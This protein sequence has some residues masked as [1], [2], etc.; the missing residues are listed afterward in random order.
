MVTPLSSPI[1]PIN[2]TQ[3]FEDF[4]RLFEETPGEYKYQEQIKN[5]DAKGRKTLIILYEDLLS[6][7]SQ[8]A[9]MLKNDPEILI[10]D[11]IKAFKNILKFHSGGTINYDEY[12]V[13]ITTKDEKSPL[14]ISIRGLRSKNIDKL[15]CVK[16]ITIRSSV[17]RPKLIKAIFECNICGA[18]FEVLQLTSSIRWPNFCHN[19]RCKAKAKS[20]FRLISKKS[21]FIDWQSITVQE[22]PEDLPPGRIPRAIQAILTHDLVDYVKPGDRIKIVGIFKSVIATS[23][24]SNNSTLFKTF[25]DVNYIDPEDKSEEQIDI[26]KEEKKEIEKLAKEPFIQRKITRSIAPTIYGRNDLKMACALTLFAGTRKKKI[27]GNY[28][29]GDIHVLFVGDPGTGKSIHGSEKIYIGTEINN[30]KIWDLTK[31]SDFIDELMNQNPSKIILKGDSEVLKLENSPKQYTYSINF[32]NFKTQI[33]QI[34]EISRHMTNILIKINTKNGRKIIATPNHSF[35]T[36]INGKLELI[37]ANQLCEIKNSN[38]LSKNKKRY[39]LPVA[40]NLRCEVN[41]HKADMSPFINKKDCQSSLKIKEQLSLYNKGI[42]SLKNA[43]IVS[44]IGKS[45]LLLYKKEPNVIPSGDWIRK[46]RNNNWIPHNITLNEEFGRIIGFYIA[47]GDISQNSVRITNTNPDVVKILQKDIKS[48]FN[49]VSIYNYDNTIQ[50]HNEV[51]MKWIKKFFGNHAKFKKISSKILF[52]PETFRRGLL[53]AYFTGDSY[54]EKNMLYIEASTASKDLAYNLSDMLCSFGIFATIGIKEI[55]SG[56]YKGNLYHTIILTGEETIKYYKIIGFLIKEKK[57]KLEKSIELASQTSR[58]QKKDIIPNFGDILQNI[59]RELGNFNRRGTWLRKFSAELRV[60]TQRQRVGRQYLR[61]VIKKLELL[62]NERDKEYNNDLK[63]LKLLSESDILWDEIDKI[64]IIKRKTYVYDIGTKDHHFIVANGNLIVHNSEILKSSVDISPRGL[65]TS[66]KGASAVGL[67]AAVIKDTDTGQMNLEAGAIVLAN[68]GVAA[69]DEFDKMSTADRSALHEAMEQQTISIAKAGIVATLK[70]ETAVIAAA[71]PHSGRYDI[72]KTPTQNIRLPPSLLSRF[73][74]IFV[75]VDRPNKA[76][77]AQMAEFILQSAMID[78]D[79]ENFSEK[80]ENFAPISGE[81]LKKYIKHAK[82]TCKPTLTKEAKKYIK[83]FYLELRGEY[84]SEDAIIS[85]LA[86][87]LDALV[88]LSEAHAKMALREKV[89]KEDVIEI[90]KLFKRY[91][92]DTGYDETTGK[93]DVDRI[94]VGESRS[95]LNKFDKLLT[96][97]KEVFEENDWK[98]LERKSVAQILYLEEG[99]EGDY[100]KKAI[101]DLITQGILYEPRTGYIKF[102]SKD[103]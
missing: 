83:D 31:I 49:K 85:I 38:R 79:N 89:L 77:D 9:E 84:S 82:R 94:F 50:I 34:N 40:R 45:T 102:T 93:I 75:V 14:T 70:A 57:I 21:D 17:V 92:R 56:I 1:S 81:L 32:N 4:Y 103:L 96:R 73:D 63:W 5:I 27:G 15:V 66:G 86:R 88:R 68:G 99:L 2:Q 33:S 51:F 11:A 101:D 74:L 76:D 7:D 37:D 54:I 87:N 59:I 65:Y 20:D 72:Y 55:K 90:I 64:D 47:E 22:V 67:T 91:L 35:T 8:I 6:F 100:I 97:L 62:Y 61:K 3:R 10:E 43:A 23:M 24:N 48:I 52:T 25:I 42:V 69:I 16:G 44:N 60:K 58:Y 78:S 12:S 39:Y 19:K 29:R 18:A 71:N 13:R 41:Y 30:G 36:L 53:S 80:E 26:T 95:K 28:K 46:K 98:M